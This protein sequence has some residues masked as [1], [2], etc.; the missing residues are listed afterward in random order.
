MTPG[1]PVHLCPYRPIRIPY[2]LTCIGTSLSTLSVGKNRNPQTHLESDLLR[3]NVVRRYCQLYISSANSPLTSEFHT[4]MLL[5]VEY[6][7]RMDVK[8]GSDWT[9]RDVKVKEAV[10]NYF[11]SRFNSINPACLLQIS[12]RI[13][14][15]SSAHSSLIKHSCLYFPH[16]GRFSGPG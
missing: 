15:C 8:Y 7:E 6:E 16:H 10:M 13:L 14:A 12:S 9:G 3:T 5:L 2:I 1:P 11:Y 4:M